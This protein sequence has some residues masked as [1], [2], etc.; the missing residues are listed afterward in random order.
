MII[1]PPSAA[2]T[3]RGVGWSARAAWTTKCRRGDSFAGTGIGARP[4]CVVH[5]LECNRP[6]ARIAYRGANFDVQLLCLS[7]G[8]PKDAIGFI[9]GK[10]HRSFPPRGTLMFARRRHYSSQWIVVHNADGL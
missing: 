5:A 7:Q 3:P 1:W 2:A 6:A 9:Q 4:N 8:A 10:T